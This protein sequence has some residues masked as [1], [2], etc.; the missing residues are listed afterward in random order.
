MG[1]S[2]GILKNT[3]SDGLKYLCRL[4]ILNKQKCEHDDMVKLEIDFPE[5]DYNFINH[6]S[7][8]V[9]ENINKFVVATVHDN[10]IRL[11]S[12]IKEIV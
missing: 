2:T 12:E 4:I 9:E 6:F 10:I 1:I 3:E 11:K 7:Q 5:D 8:I